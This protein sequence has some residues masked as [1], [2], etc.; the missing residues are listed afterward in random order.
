MNTL[1]A[2]NLSTYRSN[3]PRITYCPPMPAQGAVL[4]R[5]QS[6]RRT[7]LPV[8]LPNEHEDGTFDRGL[9]FDDFSRCQTESHTRGTKHLAVPAWTM[10]PK[11]FGIVV[12]EFLARR[13]LSPLTR[14]AFR[15]TDREL[16]YVILAATKNKR[17]GLEVIVK[18]L[19]REFTEHR[20]CTSPLCVKRRKVLASEIKN[21]DRQLRLLSR[22]DVIVNA[23]HLYY[24]NG[25][26]S[27][28]VAHELGGLVSPWGVRALICRMNNTAQ[29]L[30]YEVAHRA[31]RR[32][33]AERAAQ[34]LAKRAAKDY[35]HTPEQRRISNAANSRRWREKHKTA[36]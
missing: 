4:V 12:L 33:D 22:P 36:R 18:R 16:M 31:P 26:S 25:F 9:S 3:T 20:E 21:T 10:N 13:V 2:D 29:S 32:G 35:A 1:T 17:A 6:L 28:E 27:P 5:H 7:V 24:R 11:S 8:H 30:G 19:C 23:A 15:G 34:R 14:N